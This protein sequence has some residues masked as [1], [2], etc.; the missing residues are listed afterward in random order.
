MHNFLLT[1]EV[2]RGFDSSHTV[3]WSQM[4]EDIGLNAYFKHSK[5]GTYIDLGAFHPNRYSNTRLLYQRGWRGVN[6]DANYDLISNFMV[7]RPEDKNI[8]AA[9]GSKSEYPLYVMSEGLV[10]TTIKEL[11]DQEIAIGRK[12][13]AQRLVKGITLRSILDKYFLEERLTL[14]TIDI[15]GADYDA[16]NSIGFETLESSR[17]PEFLM[18]ETTPPVSRALSYPSV[19]LA[20]NWGYIPA[21]ILPI[22]TL[23]IAPDKI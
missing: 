16:L 8:C 9:V 13:I 1:A 22:A 12:E 11:R 3:S 6:I 20:Q 14:L 21:L 7:E 5:S 2:T 23:L 15:E 18:V 19:K 4:G 10:T 17:L